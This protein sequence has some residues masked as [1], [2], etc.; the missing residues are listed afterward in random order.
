ME[1]LILQVET[2]RLA[3]SRF[4]ITRRS[5]EL[6]GAAS[7]ALSGELSLADAVTSV[8]G[9][10]TGSPRV[11]LC[12]PPGLFAQRSTPLPFGDLRKVREVLPAQLQGEIA[13]PVEELVIDA[14]PAGDGR[15]LA[16]WARKNDISRA[17]ALFRDAGIEPQVVSSLHLGWRF[18]P[19]AAPDGAI[20]DGSVLA[21]MNGGTLSFFKA[22]ELS[23]AATLIPATLSALQLAGGKLP[24]KLSLLGSAC[25]LKPELGE[26][27][28]AVETLRPPDGTGLLFKSERAFHDLA[29]PCAAA[30]ACHSSALPDF[31]RGELAW[32]AGDA[33]LRSKLLLAGILIAIVI[34]LLFASKGMQYRSAK[35]DIASLD[36]SVAG[37]Y[38]EIFPTRT[39]AV[40]ELTEVKGEIRKL[41]GI[42]NQISHLDVLKKL[43]EAKGSN[44]NGL[45]E[46]ELE[47]RTLRLKGDARSAQAVNEFKSALAPLLSTSDTGEIKSRPDGSVTFTLTGTLREVKP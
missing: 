35:S 10:I 34:V 39:K 22:I 27:P 4:E 14:L 11:L 7:V 43:A 23:A 36:K 17:V 13:L 28:L 32:T 47:G 31:R 26:L 2:D 44:I 12:L 46:T 5:T 30:L 21:I 9:N 40:D 38:R 20:Y 45:Y 16:V 19:G 1:Y 25:G 3:I 42:D 41:S 18:L 24:E 33:G 37:I 6:L 15:F 8:A 29:S